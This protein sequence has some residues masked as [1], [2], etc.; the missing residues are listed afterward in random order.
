MDRRS[1]ESEYEDILAAPDVVLKA[2]EASKRGFD[3]VV[4][5]CMLDPGVDQTRE[6]LDIPVLGP[7]QTA[8]HVASM[9]GDKFSIITVL[10]R[11]IGP[12]I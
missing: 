1:I 6:M 3:A 2:L 8:M 4:V 5:S 10:D 11:L 7:A 12:F 9:L